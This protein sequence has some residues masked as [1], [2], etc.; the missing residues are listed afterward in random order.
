MQS[1]KNKSAGAIKVRLP[2]GKVLFLGP[3][4]MSE[5][6]DK[7]LEYSGVRKLVDEGVLEVLRHQTASKSPVGG[8]RGAKP[9][10]AR[11]T[12]NSGVGSHTTG[13]R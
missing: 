12:P 13:D 6:S 3:G 9:S 2:G 7:A 10:P 1:V 4:K 11:P 5:I 8:Q